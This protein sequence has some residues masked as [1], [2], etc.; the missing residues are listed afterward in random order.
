MTKNK[1][2]S[3]LGPVK[4]FKYYS[5]NSLKENPKECASVVVDG[6]ENTSKHFLERSPVV[7]G[8]AMEVRHDYL[9][10]LLHK[11]GAPNIGQNG[12][13]CI[14]KYIFN[15]PVDCITEIRKFKIKM[16]HF[17]KIIL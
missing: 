12:R 1:T 6:M 13:E 9:N 5:N 3:G 11:A 7:H 4:T 8:V 14:N 15:F 17:P 2:V 10:C 16:G